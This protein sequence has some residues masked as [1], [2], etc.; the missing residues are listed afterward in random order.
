[1]IT[2]PIATSERI[3][4]RGKMSR[5]STAR[6]TYRLATGMAVVALSAFGCSTTSEDESG[7]ATESEFIQAD[8]DE[9]E[10]TTVSDGSS[11]DLQ[12]VYFDYDRSNIRDDARPVLRSNGDRLRGAGAAVRL[13]GYCDERGDEEY[14]LALG[15]RRANSVKAYLE[16]LGV[17]SSQMRTISYGEA[18][19]A[20]PGHTEEAWRYNRRVE[21]RTGR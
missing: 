2:I 1:M 21:F 8:V 4:M 7:S 5:G 13:E 18:K 10:R 6:I 15:E 19:P 14:N 16:N 9:V 11:L 17:P 12:T 20:V 3:G